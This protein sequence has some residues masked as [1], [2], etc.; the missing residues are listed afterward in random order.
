[1][2]SLI[3][4]LSKAG[5]NLNIAGQKIQ[6]E[7]RRN[8][9]PEIRQLIRDNKERLLRQLKQPVYTLWFYRIGNQPGYTRQGL[10]TAD[11]DK[12]QSI[13][14]DMYQQPVTGLHKR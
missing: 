8:I 13:L 12:A 4:K 7:P 3:A 9:T 2:Q 6:A 1:M 10:M 5:V 14:G 11:K